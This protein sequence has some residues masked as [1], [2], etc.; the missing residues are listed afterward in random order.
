MNNILKN[1]G[2]IEMVRTI[3][4]EINQ[5]PERISTRIKIGEEYEEILKKAFGTVPSYIAGNPMVPPTVFL[6][7]NKF[8][9]TSLEIESWEVKDVETIINEIQRDL[10]TW[11]EVKCLFCFENMHTAWFRWHYLKMHPDSISL[12]TLSLLGYLKT[13]IRWGG[14]NL[15]PPP[16]NP[17]FNVQI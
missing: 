2:D 4:K 14:V 8:C 15:T 3:E 13:R 11:K 10:R 1:H 7:F 9:S 17:M 16:L 6:K 12:L 5:N